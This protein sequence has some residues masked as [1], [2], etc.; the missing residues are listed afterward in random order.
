MGIK[1]SLTTA[2]GEYIS[3]MIFYQFM[4]H[5]QARKSRQGVIVGG[6]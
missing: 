2:N 5:P 4:E 6:T 1:T 3:F